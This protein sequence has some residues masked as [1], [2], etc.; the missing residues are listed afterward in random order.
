MQSFRLFFWSFYLLIHEFFSQLTE[1]VT[2]DNDT[3]VLLHV[4]FRHGNRTV[5][6]P[7]ELYPKDPYLNETYF[8]FGL[9]QLTN[10]GKVREYSVGKALRKRYDNFLGGYY[11]PE[12]VEG[13]STDYNRTKM[14]L[15]LV[16]AGLFP[17]QK[18]ET[19]NQDLPWHPIPYN[20]HQ[21]ADDKVLLGVTCPYYL[22]LYDQVV[23]SRNYQ[24]KVRKNR[25][26]FAYISNNTGL[27]VTKFLDV[28]NLYFGLATEEEWGFKLPEWTKSVWPKTIIDLSIEEYFAS[29]ATTELNRMASGY[30]LQKIITDTK[31]KIQTGNE[32]KIYLYSAH[33]NNIAELLILLGIFEPLH[34]PD[35]GS[36]LTFEV[37]RV[38]DKYGIKIYYENYTGGG[39]KLMKLPACETFCEFDK[40]MSLIEEYMPVD[41]PC[42]K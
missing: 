30:F 7:E 20:Y 28:Y 3:L 5:N 37:H 22:K 4:I 17:P 14:S 32:R 6:G 35:Y 40:F 1:N 8:P 25:E 2:Q 23:E 36:Y 26:I 29:T 10:A 11:H 31:K 15:E 27:N 33:E 21:R 24:T 12:L 18:E 9:G 39:P 42:S 34:I 19:W 16:F 38:G 13:W 41:D